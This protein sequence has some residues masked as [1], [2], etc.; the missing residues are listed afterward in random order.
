MFRLLVFLLEGDSR[1][2]LKLPSTL[3]IKTTNPFFTYLFL[4]QPSLREKSPLPN[5]WQQQ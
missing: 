4:C 3:Q 1:K 2:V 5:S